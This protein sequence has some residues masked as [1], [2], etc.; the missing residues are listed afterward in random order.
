MRTRNSLTRLKHGCISTPCNER[1]DASA[2]KVSLKQTDGQDARLLNWIPVPSVGFN[3]VSAPG[4]EFFMKEARW[5]W[6]LT[7]RELMRFR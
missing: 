4:I 3:F 7:K 6:T 5:V 2:R 1:S